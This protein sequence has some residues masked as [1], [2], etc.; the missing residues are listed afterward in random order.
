MLHIGILGHSADGSALCYLETVRESA[1]RLGD[2]THPEIT[3]SLMPMGP[4]IPWWEAGDLD[5]INVHLRATA[6]RLA[7]AGCDFFVCPDN[8]AHIALEASR[9]LYPLP[10]LHIA[11][12]V[13]R[14]AKAEGR[15]RIALLGTRYTMEGSVYTAAFARHGL[16]MR[17]PGAADRRLLNA[18]IF[19]ELCLGRFEE[20]ARSEFLRVIDALKTEG[21][22]A[23]AL[24]CTEIPILITPEI[25]PLPTLDSTR[26]LAHAAVAVATGQQPKATWRGGPL[27]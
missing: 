22:D 4:T 9:E 20:S 25:S 13:A 15:R 27:N 18:I 12:V 8:T 7:R 19:D 16:E 26:L 11:E 23:A 3:L 2:H 17:T 24:C 14:Q 5:Q 10:G 21:C 1:R 6:E